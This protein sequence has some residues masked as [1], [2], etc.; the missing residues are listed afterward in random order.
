M[1]YFQ[2]IP[3]VLALATTA[4]AACTSG[5]D[6]DTYEAGFDQ[7]QLQYD[8]AWSF[9][10]YMCSS[11]QDIYDQVSK[12]GPGKSAPQCQVEGFAAGLDASVAAAEKDCPVLPD[13]CSSESTYKAGANQAEV[14]FSASFKYAGCENVD[15]VMQ[16]T[17]ESGPVEPPCLQMGFQDQLWLSYT[18][19][20][21]ECGG[22]TCESR[23]EKLAEDHWGE[24]VD[25]IGSE[26]SSADQVLTQCLGAAPATPQCTYDAYVAK[27]QS[28]YEDK[29]DDCIEEC[30][31]NG[32]KYGE[33]LGAQ[34][35]SVTV[36]FSF[37]GGE[38]FIVTICNQE[39][40]KACEAELESYVL[41]ICK[42]DYENGKNDEYYEELKAGCS[43][44][45]GPDQPTS[46]STPTPKPDPDCAEKGKAL[47]E[48][49]W[50]QARKQVGDTCHDIDMAFA[51]VNKNAPTTPA[52]VYEA[53]L[54]AVSD[55]YVKAQESCVNECAGYGETRG[56]NA[57]D[58]FCGVVALFFLDDQSDEGITIYVCNEIEK[59][60]CYDAFDTKIEETDGC[61]E[62]VDNADESTEDFY[63]EVQEV[64]EITIG[65]DQ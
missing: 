21:E 8:A 36:L 33:R 16:I 53:Y 30:Q 52:C 12:A 44:T 45:I 57:A 54:D 59:K 1:R 41:D 3:L 23:A 11:R 49:A 58:Q 31:G 38:S 10:N 19:A 32:Q 13:G 51:E 15:N 64:C 40:Q 39:E 18:E 46:T 29:F 37:A 35:C 5:V 26:C 14:Q 65:P 6:E 50:T 27:V 61:S 17:S 25:M 43:I 60:A 55:M 48:D 62:R 28:L 56:Q 20:G 7:A 22:T 24:T 47:G 9:V 4:L 63:N 42:D 2:G 34:F